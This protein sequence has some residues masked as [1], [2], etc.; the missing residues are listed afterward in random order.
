MIMA[1]PGLF[2]YIFSEQK[3]EKISVFFFYLAVKFSIY[4]N[5]L[6]FVMCCTHTAVLEHWYVRRQIFAIYGYNPENTPIQIYR[7]FHL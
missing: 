4:L 6:V 5:R 7:K 3:Y 2:Y 1:L